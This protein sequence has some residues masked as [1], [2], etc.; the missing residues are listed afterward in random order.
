MVCFIARTITLYDVICVSI[1]PPPTRRREN[2]L[3][4]VQTHVLRYFFCTGRCGNVHIIMWVVIGHLR[5][6]LS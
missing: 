2:D 1:P 5:Q 6:V 3:F 4:L